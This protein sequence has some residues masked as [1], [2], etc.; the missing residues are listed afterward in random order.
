M[1]IAKGG[2][3]LPWE[4][5]GDSFYNSFPKE[6]A[7]ARDKARANTTISTDPHMAKNLSRILDRL[8]PRFKASRLVSS[9][10]GKIVGFPAGGKAGTPA[11]RLAKV[12]AKASSTSGGVGGT[13]GSQ[14]LVT[15]A[16]G[17]PVIAKEAQLRG[18]YPTF[19]WKEFPKEHQ[20]Y[21]ADYNPKDNETDQDG[22]AYQGAVYLNIRHPVFVQE[23]TY[24]SDAVWPKADPK[25]V[26]KL[27]R[28]VYGQEAVAHVVHAQRLNG[29]VVG[30][31]EDGTVNR[32]GPE[33]VAEL[34]GRPALSAALLGLVNV[35]QRLL[36]QGG[37]QFGSRANA[38]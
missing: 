6:L 32:L 25:E 35:E 22:N 10:M 2:S 28:S 33:D 29:S 7:H 24:W 18:G 30:R 8:N 38:S 11:T 21:L 19:I 34:V 36:T 20:K 15:A 14:D 9:A 31:E 17:G 37:G 3:E 26:A 16:P 23:M 1:L 13:A 27:V 4:A 12:P 5:W